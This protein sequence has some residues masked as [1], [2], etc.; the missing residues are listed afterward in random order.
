MLIDLVISILADIGLRSCSVYFPHLTG[1]SLVL[2]TTLSSPHS[3]NID[4]NISVKTIYTL[5]VHK[6][7]FNF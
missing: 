6:T 4:T 1:H 7:F 5:T 2:L 3:E